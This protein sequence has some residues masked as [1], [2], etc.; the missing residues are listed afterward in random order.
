MKLKSIIS[1]I[2][3]IALLTACDDNTSTLGVDMMPEDDFMTSYCD[4]FEVTTASYP[5]GNSV[6]ARTSMSYFGQF[7]DPETG[8]IVKSD[9]LAQFHCNEYFAFPEKVVDNKITKTEIKLYVEKFVGDSL[10]SFKL[11]VYPLNKV[12]DPDKNYYTDIDPTMYYDTNSQPVAVK[13]FTLSDRTVS[14]ADRWDSE[15]YNNITISLPTSIGQTIYDSYLQD[16][17]I[18]TNTSTWAN[19]DILGSKGFYFKLE[20]GDGAMAYI[21]IA[22]FNIHFNYYDETYE[23]DTTGVC[24]FAATE[25]V[26]QANS[27]KNSNLEPLLEDNTGTYIKSPAGIFTIATLPIDEIAEAIANDTINAAKLTFVRY[28]DKTESKFK[29]EIPQKLL[30]VRLDEYNNG[31]FEKYSLID[32]KTSFIATFNSQYNTYEFP[33]ISKL[34]THC[35]SEKK[36]GTAT[37]NWNKVLLIPVEATY[38]SSN[39]LVK[40]SHDFSMS[41]SKLVGGVDP[42]GLEIIYSRFNT[43]N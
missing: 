9:F 17:E 1:L 31:F 36:Y 35:I 41:S 26:I 13:W 15:Y 28:N 3:P 12:L 24:Q 20:S 27:F 34:V 29:L 21:D 19:S 11:S 43:S 30:M 6:L 39:L 18:F 33:N 42:V 10:T 37:E 32:N 7:T 40:L 14:D 25:E 2:F 23:K 38:D 5:V 16:P 8:T 4:S 22:Q